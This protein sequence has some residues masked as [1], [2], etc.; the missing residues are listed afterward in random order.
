MFFVYFSGMD[1]EGYKDIKFSLD[2]ETYSFNS[3]GKNGQLVKIVKFSIL[4]DIPDAYNLSL[5]TIRWHK[6]DFTEITDN[7]DRDR[8]LSTIFT[9]SLEFSNRYPNRKIFI[10]GRNEAT[11]RL[12]R[13]AINHSYSQLTEAF[14]IWGVNYIIDEDD[15]AF[16]P[17]EK[18]Q[19]YDA[20]LFERRK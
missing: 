14:V 3:I 9:I 6:V 16:E 2:H 8:I 19:K 10:R 18:N 4:E 15:Y 5:G 1:I 12:Y 13:A 17:F 7:G 11:T 20:F